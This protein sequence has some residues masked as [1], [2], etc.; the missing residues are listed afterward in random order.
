M[1][2]KPK[3]LTVVLVSV[4]AA[5]LV[6]CSEPP[7]EQALPQILT[8]MTGP[9]GGGSDPLGRRVVSALNEQMDDVQLRAMSSA[10][11]VANVQAIESGDADLAI[12][13]ADV[14][15]LGYSGRLDPSMAPLTS[16]RGITVLHLT[17]VALAVREGLVIESPAELRGLSV[18]VGPLGSGTALTAQLILDAFGLD[19]SQVEIRTLGFSEAARQ[20]RLG[21][22]DAMFDNAIYQAE[23]L[24]EA[25]EAGARLVN[26]E[27]P[28]VSRLRSEY[29]FLRPAIIPVGLYPSL[30]GSTHTVGVD[31]LLI[32][33]ND[34]PD[35]LVYDVT[36]EFFNVL[37]RLSLMGEVDLD[38]APATTI[39]LHP[40]AARYYREREL[41]R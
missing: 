39:P 16:I 20:L 6:G 24:I 36:R 22:L 17:P 4:M 23:S 27:G 18:A 19:A 34:L 29:P 28:F 25:T 3:A 30:P 12:T 15:Y 1:T 5:T 13:F 31:G 37:P 26:V 7:I 38:F 2:R 41:F 21:E 35:D 14:A 40:G 33:R 32:G 11:A 8:L 9:E 10:G